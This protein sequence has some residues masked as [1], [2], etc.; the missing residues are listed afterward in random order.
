MSSLAWFG[1][2]PLLVLVGLPLGPL[3]L[4][5][6]LVLGWRGCQVLILKVFVGNGFRLIIFVD[7]VVSSD[8]S[9]HPDVWT[10]GSFV[11]DELSGIG[12]GGCGVYSLKSGAGWFG[13]RWCHLEW[14]PPGDLGVERCVLFDSIRGPLQ[15]VQRAELWCVILAVQCSSAVHLGVDNLNVVRHVSRIW[16]GGG[17][18]CRPFELTIDG[19][20][21]TVIE[22]MILQRGTRSVR[23]SKVKGHKD[24]EMVAVGRVRVEDRIRNDLADRAADFGRRRVSDLVMDV[25]R[26][27][28]SACSSWYPVVLELHRFYGCAGV[29]LHP[30]VWSSGGLV[31]RRKTRV[32]AWEYAWV[33]GPVGL[34]RHGSVGW[35]CIEVRDVDVG[36]WPGSFGLLVKLCS[37]LSSLHWPSTV[38]DLGVGGVSFIELLILYERWAGERLVLE[39][40]VPRSRRLHRPISVSAVPA[41]PSIDIWRSCR[42]LVAMLRALGGLP[43][44]LGRFLPCRLGAN[45]CRLRSVGWERCGH[46]LTSWPL[47]ASGTG[48][49]DDLLSLFH[50][51]SGSRQSLIDGSLRMRY[52]SSNFSQQVAAFWWRGSSGF[53]CCCSSA[54]GWFAGFW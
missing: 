3:R 28:V 43:G 31:K 41:G 38:S 15:S 34:W 44:G 50:Y 51:P 10:D 12:V 33:P 8:V 35:P 16:D 18:A 1:Y 13:R 29:A 24:D 20:L 53:C 19:D 23:I 9:D 39:M 32:S 37:F 26:R 14:L 52:C 30:I 22:K 21:L 17:V 36:F 11:L 4:M 49:L 25:R 2:L 40:S 54:G 47:E 45:H 42:F 46:G 5:I 48:F 7:S 6:L 27:F